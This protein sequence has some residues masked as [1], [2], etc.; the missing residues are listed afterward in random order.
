ME[1]DLNGHFALS[2]PLRAQEGGRILGMLTVARDTSGFSDPE[3]ELFTYLSQQA[4]VSI[5]NVDLHE[6][7]QRQAVTDELTGLFNHRRFQEVIFQEVER[8]KRF[9]DDVGLIMLDIDN[10]KRVNDTYGHMQGD[11]VLR[12]VARV[13]RESS[14]EIDE[15][16][17]YGG[18]EMAVALPGTDLDGA[19]N[20]A[21]RVRHAIE[22]LELPLID[23]DGTLRVTASFGAAAVER[24]ERGGGQG[25]PRGR[26]RR[27]AL[28]RQALR[29][30][31][32]RSSGV[33]FNG[34][35]GLLDDA[36][37]EHLE[38]K[39]R[40]GAD[41]EEVT[42]Q[43]QEALGAPQR[44]E[45]AGAA[46][47]ATAEPEAVEDAPAPD[48]EPVTEREPEPDIPLDQA[49][50]EYTPPPPDEPEEREEPPTPPQEGDEDVLEETPDF[51]QETPEH[52]RLWFEQKPPRDFD[53][54]R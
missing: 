20:F 53:L 43:E 42:R 45:F 19:Y 6:T 13:L 35:M 10:F 38:L 33:G 4:G 14:R 2:H 1:T 48:P 44:A 37:R 3:R 46:P 18:E 7:V 26:G 25:R 54:D 5:E 40:R 50:V 32:H 31:P 16:A 23:G 11:L 27:G 47:A 17:R 51:L 9:G 30:E 12:E 22:S 34:E 21:E 15:P 8:A 24:R 41:A 49:T 29:E 52:D 36:I 28:S 39:R